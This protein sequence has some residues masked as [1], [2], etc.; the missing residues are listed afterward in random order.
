MTIRWR[1]AGASDIG[2]VRRT[3][4][5]SWDVDEGNGLFLVADGMGGHAAGEVASALVVRSVRASLVGIGS[6]ADAE[7]GGLLADAFHQARESLTEH[8][9]HDRRTR[10]MGTTLTVAVLRPEGTVFTG[11][12]GDSRL[13]HLSASG[14][15]QLTRDHTWHQREI[16]SGRRPAGS[17][18]D[19][20]RL[21]HILTR[22]VSADEPA[23]PDLSS[24]ALAAGETLLLCSDGLYNLVGDDDLAEILCRETPE[25]QTVGALI[26]EANRRGGHDNTTA[27]VIRIN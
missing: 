27:I 9:F 24:A 14:L 21:S 6:V 12:L 26:A 25:E 5:D 10:G 15:R 3:N 1:A 22:V 8:V 16:D 7:V 2:K 19:N 4:E 18:P 11:H 20:P 13:Y 17:D 23:A